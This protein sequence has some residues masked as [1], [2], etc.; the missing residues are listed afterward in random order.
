MKVG[1]RLGLGFGGVILLL[2]LI[3]LIGVVNIQRVNSAVD[4]L[5]NDRLPK[6]VLTHDIVDNVNIGARAIRNALLLDDKAKID[7]EIGRIQDSRKSIQGDI[8]QLQEKIKTLAGKELLGK[9]IDSRQLYVQAQDKVLALVSQGKGD[10]ARDFLLTEVRGKQTA[11]LKAVSNVVEYQIRLMKESGQAAAE[12]AGNTRTLLIAL[13]AFA[14]LLSAMSAYFIVRGILKQLG[15]EPGLAAAIATRI[16]AGDLASAIK[17]EPGDTTSLMACMSRMSAAI[18]ALVEDAG[19]LARAA[20]AGDLSVRADPSQHQGDFRKVMEGVNATL[21]AII[22][23]LN[24]A[25]DYVDR[26]AKG[27]LPPAITDRCNGDFNAI[28]NNLNQA[29]ANIHKLVDDAEMLHQ[30]A[31]AGQLEVRAEAD[32]HHGDYR[33]IIEGFNDTLDAMVGPIQDVE[34]VLADLAEGDLTGKITADY[35]GTFEKLRDDANTTV[36]R[37]TSMIQDI[38]SATD[39][40]NTAS[41]EIS[42]GNLYLAQRTE[43]QAASLEETA[44]SMQEL[45]AT[46]KQNDDNAKQA[47]QMASAASGVAVE[48]HQ[49]VRQVMDT[50]NGIGESSRQISNIIGLIDS[51]A[52][53]TNILALNAAVEAARAGEQGRGFA[54]VAVEVRNLAKRTTESAK[55][56]KSLIGDSA[57]TVASGI[58][59]VSV[60]DETMDKMVAAVNQV[61]NL[62]AQIAS[63][64]AAQTEG[65]GQV[66]QAVKQMDEL[67]QQNAALVEQAAAAAESLEEQ[68]TTLSWSTGRFRLSLTDWMPEEKPA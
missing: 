8:D 31:L 33:K 5:I 65:I 24:M 10:M 50:M 66:N 36:D 44:A 60:A 7:F 62:M 46:V 42:K 13:A 68:A 45:A 35:Q 57:A 39:T 41:R 64:S 2:V 6:A 27:S 49:V 58:K 22:G 11:Y 18:K 67:T 61:T 25:A 48:G 52:F 47:K 29:I 59:L 28:K 20:V 32:Q 38:K 34:R 37:L 53:Q 4:I 15:G 9:L 26:I 1:M 17:L 23:P 51:I 55:E 54:V 30:A 63:A 19:A 12:I 40:I 14:L 56:I 16:A 21:D 43:E 3:V